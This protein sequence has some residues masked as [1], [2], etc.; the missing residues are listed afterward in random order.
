[1]TSRVS[2][3]G[4]CRFSTQTWLV[5]AI[6]LKSSFISHGCFREMFHLHKALFPFDFCLFVSGKQA[7]GLM[8]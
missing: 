5:K 8:P 4:R 2:V 6:M 3:S 7:A 1:M